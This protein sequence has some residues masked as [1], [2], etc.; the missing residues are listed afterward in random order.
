M[1]TIICYNGG[2]THY[3]KGNSP[4]S[5]NCT[6]RGYDESPTSQTLLHKIKF[7]LVKAFYIV[8]FM[9]TNKKEIASTELSRKLSLRQKTCCHLR[10]R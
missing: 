8:H 7:D 2:H 3:C 10:K 4:Y 5:R 1:P 9:S 6:S